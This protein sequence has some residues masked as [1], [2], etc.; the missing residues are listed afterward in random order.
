ML[1]ARWSG[2]IEWCC[3]SCNTYRVGILKA[4]H[5]ALYC[6]LCRTTYYI[7]VVLYKAPRGPKPLYPRDTLMLADCFPLKR[8]VNRCY[9]AKCA[10]LI[11]PD[12]IETMLEYQSPLDKATQDKTL[13]MLKPRKQR[14]DKA[15]T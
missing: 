1:F 15:P 3:P 6:Q 9:C 5:K 11:V 12:V 14:G 2:R 7:G 8:E 13:P 10:E 4:R